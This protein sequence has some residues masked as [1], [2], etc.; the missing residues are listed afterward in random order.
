MILGNEILKVLQKKYE[1]LSFIQTTFKRYDIAF[2]TDEEGRPVLLFM[3]KAG[4]DGKIKGERFARRLVFGENG[5]IIKD[6]WDNK[7]KVS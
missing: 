5:E 1:A 7:G 3:G 2:K 6:H 4:D